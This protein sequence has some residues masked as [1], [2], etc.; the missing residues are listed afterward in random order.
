MNIK[1]VGNPKT[2]NL[3]DVIKMI[4]ELGLKPKLDWKEV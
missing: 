4:K 3:K 2:G 1:G